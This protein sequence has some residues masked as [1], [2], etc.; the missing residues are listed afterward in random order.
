MC[1]F[2]FVDCNAWFKRMFWNHVFVPL[3]DI[4][5]QAELYVSPLIYLAPR[6]RHLI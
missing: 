1:Q 2:D 4:Q 5:I 6:F 3:S